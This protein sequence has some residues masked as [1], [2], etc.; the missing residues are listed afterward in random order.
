MFIRGIVMK[1]N[2]IY[3]TEIELENIKKYANNV[4]ISKSEMIRRIIDLYI[5]EKENGK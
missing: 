1:R 3:L 4:G 5:E 2:Q